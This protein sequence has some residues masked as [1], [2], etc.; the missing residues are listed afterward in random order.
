MKLKLKEIKHDRNGF[1]YFVKVKVNGKKAEFLIDTGATHSVMDS[2]GFLI[3]APNPKTQKN[4][5]LS[6]GLGTKSMESEITK[7]KSFEIGKIKFQKFQ[8]VL[9]D[10]STVN[11]SYVAIGNEPFDGILGSDVLRSL[12]AT[13][14]LNKKGSWIKLQ[15]K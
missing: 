13:I 4:E 7:L 11:E 12:N 15:Q 9:M 10:L 3:F 14:H 8:I 6:T 2:T 1:H 5:T